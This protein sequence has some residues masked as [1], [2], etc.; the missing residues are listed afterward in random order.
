MA[1]NSEPILLADYEPEEMPLF[2]KHLEAALRAHAKTLNCRTW[3]H[4]ADEICR[5]A[6][7]VLSAPQARLPEHK[8]SQ[9][10]DVDPSAST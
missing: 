3:S 8:A 4:L 9:E 2:V 10:L 5:A 1:A 7:V 6:D